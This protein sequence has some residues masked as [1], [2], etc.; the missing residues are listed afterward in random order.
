MRL[1]LSSAALLSLAIPAGLAQAEPLEVDIDDIGP[2]WEGVQFHDNF[3]W[4]VVSPGDLNGDG[5]PDFAVTGPQDDGPST[6]DSTVRV[7]LG[8][9]DRLPEEGLADWSDGTFVDAGSPD[10]S[11]FRFAIIPD[12]TGDGEPELIAAEPNGSTAGAVYM[13]AGDGNWNTE[14]TAADATARWTG[15]TQTEYPELADETRPSDVVGGDFD[16][17]GLADVAIASV[18]FNRVWIDYSSDGFAADTDLS[19][20]TTFFTACVDDFPGAG[21]GN[22]LAVGDFNDDDRADL[23]VG[24]PG[25][26]DDV[27]EVH[28]FYGAAGGLSASADL[29][30]AGGDRLGSRLF[31]EDLDGDGDD[32]LFV[33]ELLSGDNENKGGLWIF[34]GGSGGLAATPSTTLASGFSDGRLGASVAVLPDISNPPDGIP[35]LVVGSPEAS[36]SG[37]GQGAIYVFEG[38]AS[39]PA[40]LQ[41]SDAKYRV[42]GSNLNTWFGQSLATIDDFNGDGYPEI[43]IGE[44][45]FSS[46]NSENEFHRGR[47]YLFTAL[48]DRDDDGDN[49]STLNGDC[50]D[51]DPNV[52]PG[53]L[54]ECNGYDDNCNHQVDEGCGDDDDAADDDDVA[55]DDDTAGDDD[56]DTTGG[57][58][59]GSS[60][61]DA[62]Q[63]PMA[64]A[65]LVLGLGAAVVRRRA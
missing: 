63:S 32:E 65:L 18:L 53:L 50:A 49:V 4:R 3:G 41:V 45:N 2:R 5:L 19:T 64:I 16:G 10:D 51:D 36:L 47:L 52:R 15:Y 21:F 31:A 23:A 24:A 60:L 14:R 25:C 9:D 17:D 6:F 28:V 12:A 22:A 11:V 43:A 29:V 1:L 56:D 33:Q 8:R 62:Q 54:E 58:E 61:A 59:C 20:L 35:E 42:D 7:F 37:V 57:C 30:I 55:D 39:W 34:T 40:Q 26:N 48:P 44:P 27:G 46:D 13:Y 38:Q